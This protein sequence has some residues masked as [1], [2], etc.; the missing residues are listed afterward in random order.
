MGFG[1]S[2][3]RGRAV[4]PTTAPRWSA[5]SATLPWTAALLALAPGPAAAAGDDPAPVQAAPTPPSVPPPASPGAATPRPA[6]TPLALAPRRRLEPSWILETGRVPEAAPEPGVV[7]LAA[8]GEYQVRLRSQTQV[9]LPRHGEDPS[10]RRLD[11]GARLTHWLRLTPVLQVGTAFRLVAQADVPHGMIAG[12]PNRFVNAAREPWDDL[13][14]LRA[15]LRWLFLAWSSPTLALRAGQQP[16]HWG[17]GLVDH[18]GDHPPRFGD[19]VAGTRVERVSIALR[20]GGQRST[21]AVEAAGELVMMDPLADLRDRDVAWRG[22]IAIEHG[23][24]RDTGFGVRLVGRRQRSPLEASLDPDASR[25][26]TLLTANATARAAA[27]LA[28]DLGMLFGE[29]EVALNHGAWALDVPGGEGRGIDSMEVRAHGIAVRAGAVVLDG[30][31]D[32]TF[33]RFVAELEWGRASGD[34]DPYDGVDRRFRFAPGHRVGSLIFSEVL[35]WKTARSANIAEDGSL[36]PSP[37]PEGRGLATDG[38]VA[39]A[40]YLAPVV[41]VRP[42]RDLDLEVGAVIAQSTADVVDPVQLYRDGRPV[43]FD[44]GAPE[45][46]DL[47]L[48]LDAG[49][50]LRIPLSTG[51]CLQLGA[52]GAALLPGYAFA[53]ATGRRN[54]TLVSVLGR[55]GVQY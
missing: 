53:D 35:A 4:R 9:V 31:P 39:G 38:S 26:L 24:D 21:W 10:T 36:G 54:P 23:I 27:P 42:L 1:G 45:A 12:P 5:A 20:P 6:A 11:Q 46:R 19:T 16:V 41:V 30:E 14:P 2:G 32:S 15:E 34:A 17:L 44:G 55:F 37:R 25:E 28:G 50:E 13:Q 40:T 47:G 49:V 43:N 29:L 8:H 52:E 22:V 3:R 7:R 48:E 18:D 51:L 33:G